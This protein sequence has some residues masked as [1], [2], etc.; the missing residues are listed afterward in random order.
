MVRQ[1]FCLSSI[2]IEES[3]DTSPSSSLFDSSLSSVS[4]NTTPFS[5]QDRLILSSSAS[6][7]SSVVLS[8][9]SSIAIVPHCQVSRLN[10]IQS[11][12]FSHG[13]R[14]LTYAEQI[15]FHDRSLDHFPCNDIFSTKLPVCT[16][17][18]SND[19]FLS[20]FHQNILLH[21]CTT[22]KTVI[23]NVLQQQFLRIHQS[24]QVIFIE[25]QQLDCVHLR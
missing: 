18:Q 10:K 17:R 6:S 13:S 4:R 20:E 14:S 22:L 7:S 1:E 15:Y 9:I 16:S 19:G 2:I 23:D 11:S 24:S 3:L 25:H 12:T 21:H 8:P 5:S